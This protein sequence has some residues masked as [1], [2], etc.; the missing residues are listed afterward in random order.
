MLSP[1]FVALSKTRPPWLRVLAFNSLTKASNIVSTYA[2]FKE[3]TKLVFCAKCCASTF[4][5]IKL[6]KNSII[7]DLKIAKIKLLKT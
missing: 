3:P 4:I 5:V 2:C 1:E 7:K 6:L